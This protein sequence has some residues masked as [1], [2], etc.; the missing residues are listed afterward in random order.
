MLAGGPTSDLLAGHLASP[1]RTA[2]GLGMLGGVH[3]LVLTGRAP[4][5]AAFYPSA[6][7]TAD[8]GPGSGRAS[9]AARQVLA[10]QRDAVR[11][12]LDRPPQTNEAG[13]AAAL[14]RGLPHLTAEAPL[15][16]RLVESGASAGLNLRPGRFPIPPESG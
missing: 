16:V 13:P 5:L 3:A 6:G 8:A 10:D 4:E 2:L 7:G 12:W 1:W 9:A 15:P 14:L 11:D